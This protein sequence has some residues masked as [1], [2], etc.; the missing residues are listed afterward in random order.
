MNLF[1]I[2]ITFILLKVDFI[3]ANLV[4]HLTSIFQFPAFFI[5]WFAIIALPFRNLI[6]VSA[7]SI[8]TQAS[9][10]KIV[11][12]QID[13]FIVKE[14]AMCWVYYF[15]HLKEVVFFG[16]KVNHLNDDDDS[17]EHERHHNIFILF[18]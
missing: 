18:K 7:I 13:F 15:Y 8:P 4:T 9:F 5:C 3:I 1:L 17:N 6:Y 10:L 14:I 12:Q 2:D 16:L 11:I